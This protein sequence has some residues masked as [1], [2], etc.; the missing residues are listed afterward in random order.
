MERVVSY[1]RVSTK[2]QSERHGLDAQR[3]IR[4]EYAARNNLV[5]I[6]EFVEVE[7]G[8]NKER[9]VLKE[10]L[11]YCELTG[12]RLITARLDRLSRS[13]SFLGAILDSGV[14]IIICDFPNASRFVL[15]VLGCVAEYELERIRERT[16]NGLKAAKAKG[17]QLGKACHLNRDSEKFSDGRIQGSLKN[18]TKADLR[19]EK[20][21]P[22][23]LK[24]QSQGIT[25]LTAL[26]QQLTEAG[27]QTP[28]KKKVWTSQGVKNL[29]VRIGPV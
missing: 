19:A 24:F 15:N 27:I 5:V 20:L 23:I 14:E 8:S 26:A 22:E 6:K 18:R 4:A 13:L 9:P 29:L 3:T 25:S 2:S 10:A 7:S 17:V 16:K 21:K 12:C 28:R 11:N 1:D